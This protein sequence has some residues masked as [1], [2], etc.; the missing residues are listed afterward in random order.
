M[1]RKS[2]YSADGHG[3]CVELAKLPKAVGIRDSK[4]P[5][6]GHLSVSPTALSGL[7]DKIRHG[8]LDL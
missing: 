3:N 5:D 7:I 6:G 4:N 1:W 8:D 2:T